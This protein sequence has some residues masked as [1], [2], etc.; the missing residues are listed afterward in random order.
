MPP[1]TAE[2]RTP[3]APTPPRSSAA[4][5][6]EKVVDPP[7]RELLL[8]DDV[9]GWLAEDVEELAGDA[10]LP[11]A[12]DAPVVPVSDGLPAVEDPAAVE[13]VEE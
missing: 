6:L 12:V 7:G 4:G 1:I 5:G 3:K 9:P 2:S 10:G 11:V 13:D 8:A